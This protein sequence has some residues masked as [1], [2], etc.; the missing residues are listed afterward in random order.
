MRL[1]VLDFGVDKYGQNAYLYDSTDD[2]A[3]NY[4]RVLFAPTLDGNDRVADLARGE[5]ADVKVTVVGGALNGL[6]AGFLSRWR[7]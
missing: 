3:T 6:T 4:D 2:G 7:S 1:R 5:W